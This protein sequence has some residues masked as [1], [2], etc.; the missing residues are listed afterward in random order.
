MDGHLLTGVMFINARNTRRLD[1]TYR[2]R[3]R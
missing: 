2:R 3:Q 1:Q